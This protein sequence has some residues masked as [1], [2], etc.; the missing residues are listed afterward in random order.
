[1]SERIMRPKQA[2]RVVYGRQVFVKHLLAVH[3]RAHLQQVEFARAVTVYIAGE[4]NLH[5]P[6]HPLGSIFHSHLHQFGQREHSH[7]QHSAERYNLTAAIIEA[8]AY[9][10]V[11]GVVCRTDI[12]QRAVSLGI[13]HFKL[14]NVESVVYLEVAADVSHVERIELRLSLSES[15]LHLAGL[16]HL[17]WMIRTDAQSLSSIDDI[18]AQSERKTCYT[19]L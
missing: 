11:I 17:S 5:R 10:L 6:F 14:Q 9:H 18:L 7:L 8:V 1:M 13:L 2:A 4:L 3:Y 16:Q 19:V 15:N 12:V